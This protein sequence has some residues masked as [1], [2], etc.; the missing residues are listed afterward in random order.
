MIP[1]NQVKLTPGF[2]FMYESPLLRDFALD[3][4]SDRRVAKDFLRVSFDRN[5]P[6]SIVGKILKDGFYCLDPHNQKN[7]KES[8]CLYRFF[9]YTPTQVKFSR[10]S[11]Y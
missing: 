11:H 7:K 2:D 10:D 6:D 9:A 1:D 8:I 3:P 4:S 5:T